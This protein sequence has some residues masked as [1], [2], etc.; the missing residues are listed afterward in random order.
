MH[1]NIFIRNKTNLFVQEEPRNSKKKMEEKVLKRRKKKKK[2]DK[3]IKAKVEIYNFEDK[4][5]SSHLEPSLFAQTE[6]QKLMNA[7]NV[8]KRW[9]TK[10]V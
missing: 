2:K 7:A 9:V 10:A 5:S 4:R 3:E 1:K 8:K 6:R